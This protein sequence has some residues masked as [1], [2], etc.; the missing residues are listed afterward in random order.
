MVN[1]RSILDA[2]G[3]CDVIYRGKSANSQV[4]ELVVSTWPFLGPIELFSDRINS[5]ILVGAFRG[6][7][8]R[9]SSLGRLIR[10]ESAEVTAAALDDFLRR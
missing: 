3:W 10:G 6:R 4:D 5:F 8:S 9:L 2:L 7:S 1:E